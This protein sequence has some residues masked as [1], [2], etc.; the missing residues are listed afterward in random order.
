MPQT[1]SISAVRQVFVVVGPVFAGAMSSAGEATADGPVAFRSQLGDVC[2]DAPNG[3]WPSN[4][5]I[6]PCNGT[7]F[8]RWN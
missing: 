6:N 8:Q 4:V 3:G 7:D 1:R 2:L 5:M